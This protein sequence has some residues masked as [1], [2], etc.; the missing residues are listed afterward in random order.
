MALSNAER[1]RRYREN[2]KARARRSAD[3]SLR[4]LCER[5]WAEDLDERS[6]QSERSPLVEYMRATPLTQ[7]QLDTME[8]VLRN[9]VEAFV[10]QE[11]KKLEKAMRP[12]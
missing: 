4:A 3:E 9:A 7:Q 11:R 8:F 1:Q 6:S 2:L 10:L 12:R 5:L